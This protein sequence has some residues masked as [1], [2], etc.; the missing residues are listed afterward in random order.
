MISTQAPFLAPCLQSSNKFNLDPDL[1]YSGSLNVAK[2][3]KKLCAELR[4][5]QICSLVKS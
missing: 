3:A 1:G 2:N 4:Q 5:S